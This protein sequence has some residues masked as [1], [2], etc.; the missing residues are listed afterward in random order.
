MPGSDFYIEEMR[1]SIEA[2]AERDRAHRERDPDCPMCA[3]GMP[4]SGGVHHIDYTSGAVGASTEGWEKIV[5]ELGELAKWQIVVM[6]SPW[7]NQGKVRL[8]FMEGDVEYRPMETPYQIDRIT[9]ACGF[10]QIEIKTLKGRQLAGEGFEM[11]FSK[12]ELRA[13]ALA[14]DVSDEKLAAPT[15]H[16]ADPR[17]GHRHLIP[18]NPSR[19]K[20]R[21]GGRRR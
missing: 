12:I 8:N 3:V 1:E 18:G 16:E 13:L 4:M 11:D 6:P 19:A 20:K 14:G 5:A 9:E 2:A 17:G 15:Q 7:R 21:K 10:E